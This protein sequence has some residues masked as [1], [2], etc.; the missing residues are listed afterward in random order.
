MGGRLG[1]I[2]RIRRRKALLVPERR[3]HLGSGREISRGNDLLQLV[4]FGIEAVQGLVDFL[5]LAPGNA[6]RIVPVHR[7]K[8][9]HVILRDVLRESLGID[10][11]FPGNRGQP[12]AFKGGHR[13]GDVLE[14]AYVARPAVIRE[15][16]DRI[17]G[18]SDLVHPVFLGEIGSELP[19]QQV[20]I[21]LPVTEG[22]HPDLHGVQSII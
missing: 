7:R 1:H 12:V 5:L 11:A 16:L 14:L 9:V 20:D 19:E 22:G 18:E 2:A 21:L 10:L 6:L 15:H 3:S 13:L 17:V 4:D 8:S